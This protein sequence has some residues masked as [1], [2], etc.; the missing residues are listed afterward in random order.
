[1]RISVYIETLGIAG[2]AG[3]N[4]RQCNILLFS[5]QSIRNLGLIHSPIQKVPGIKWQRREADHS[6]PSN[7]EV[8]NDIDL[9]SPI[10]LHGLMLN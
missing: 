3:Y 5:T 7:A 9:H 6:P 10:C 4:S 8:K 2:L 1:M